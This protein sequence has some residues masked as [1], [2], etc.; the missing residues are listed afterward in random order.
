MT[1]KRAQGTIKVD[2]KCDP[3]M[4][5]FLTHYI[6]LPEGEKNVFI[7]QLGRL[8]STANN[9]NSTRDDDHLVGLEALLVESGRSKE[10]ATL[11][12]V[13]GKLGLAQD[14]YKVIRPTL[15]QW[16]V[17]NNVE[18]IKAFQK[19]IVQHQCVLSNHQ[20]NKQRLDFTYESIWRPVFN[21]L[22]QASEYVNVKDILATICPD[23]NVR[24]LTSIFIQRLSQFKAE[25]PINIEFFTQCYEHIVGHPE[26]KD[27][28]PKYIMFRF[29]STLSHEAFAPL[30][31]RMCHTMSFKDVMEKGPSEDFA[32]PP[33]GDEWVSFLY[34]PPEQ[35]DAHNWFQP[36]YL[37][38]Q[39]RHLGVERIVALTQAFEHNGI[40]V[41]LRDMPG[42]ECLL[43]NAGRR[44]DSAKRLD[45]AP[46][47]WL[48]QRLLVEH[49]NQAVENS[50]PHPTTVRKI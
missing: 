3:M 40:A 41:V 4:T 2:A 10:W 6:S 28:Y 43:K 34:N 19:A 38:T 24:D 33:D 1:N 50:S 11:T 8:L 13:V 31:T 39:N 46:G 14:I 32:F 16:V 12:E 30:L 21:T 7:A 35:L 36:T 49:L 23:L 44:L 22:S 9:Q 5:P 29:I 47:E 48:T 15:K 26:C 42:V 27:H 17:H 25:T 18:A 45:P 37:Q 20:Q